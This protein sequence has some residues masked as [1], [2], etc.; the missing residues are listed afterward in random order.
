[1]ARAIG[2]EYFMLGQ[3]DY[4]SRLQMIGDP[5]S[6]R[7]ARQTGGAEAAVDRY[8]RL[9]QRSAAGVKFAERIAYDLA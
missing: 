1:M 7:A 3:P 2:V 6:R 4:P 9:A 5:S 8:R